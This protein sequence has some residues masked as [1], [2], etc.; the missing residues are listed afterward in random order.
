MTTNVQKVRKVVTSKP[1]NASVQAFMKLDPADQKELLAWAEY[2][3]EDWCASFRAEIADGTYDP[4]MAEIM[5]VVEA[6]ASALGI[7]SSISSQSPGPPRRSVSGLL[8]F[9][10]GGPAAPVQI[11]SGEFSLNG[12]TYEFGKLY[13]SSIIGGGRS[14]WN[15]LVFR[16]THWGRGGTLH[17]VGVLDSP[18]LRGGAKSLVGVPFH[19]TAQAR[20]QIHLTEV[21]ILT[22]AGVGLTEGHRPCARGKTWNTDTGTYD[23]VVRVVPADEVSKVVDATGEFRCDP[24]QREHRVWNEGYQKE[25]KALQIQQDMA[26]IAARKREQQPAPKPAVAK[27]KQPK[28]VAPVVVA[29]GRRR[30]R[31]GG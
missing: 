2:T 17:G 26:A 18:Y 9:G 20:D 21:A 13:E 24:C 31:R 6:R 4:W 23:P 5:A 19:M 8:V 30:V 1:I 11:Q 29:A 3:N 10:G 16:P 27:P 12:R 7:M 14:K 22:C 25:Q 28:Q 15:G